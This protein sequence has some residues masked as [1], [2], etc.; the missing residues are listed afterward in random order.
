MGKKM[1]LS[2]LVVLLV[3]SDTKILTS[4]YFQIRKGLKFANISLIRLCQC[5]CVYCLYRGCLYWAIYHT[6]YEHSVN[7]AP[8]CE[9]IIRQM[10][11]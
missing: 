2:D 5:Y 4:L 6:N 11:K 7:C 8:R 1:F 9:S 10:N 3:V